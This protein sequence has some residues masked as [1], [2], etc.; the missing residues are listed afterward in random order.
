[1]VRWIFLCDVEAEY[2]ENSRRKRAKN[3]FW[4]LHGNCRGKVRQ[5]LRHENENA[6]SAFDQSLLDRTADSFTNFATSQ[7]TQAENSNSDY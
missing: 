3:W 5:R 1:M 4:G 2:I 6:W 7:H